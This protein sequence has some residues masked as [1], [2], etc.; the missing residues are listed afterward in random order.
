MSAPYN[1]WTV[2]R[3]PVLGWTATLPA[4][5]PVH[6][7]IAR[8]LRL[9]ERWGVYLLDELPGSGYRRA[10]HGPLGAF[11]DARPGGVVDQQVERLHPY[12]RL[13]VADVDGAVVEQDV[14][15]LGAV[16]ER[17]GSQA[18]IRHH[19]PLILDADLLDEQPVLSVRAHSDV[20]LPWCHADVSDRGGGVHGDDLV[21]NRALAERH[22][23]RLS[24]FLAELARHT[25]AAGGHW[26]LEPDDTLRSLQFELHDEGV[27]LDVAAPPALI[28]P[29]AWPGDGPD[30][31]HTALR[32]ALELARDHP[33]GSPDGIGLRVGIPPDGH[34]LGRA[35]RDE[36]LRALRAPARPELRLRADELAGVVGVD[37][38]TT[39]GRFRFGV[40]EL[41]G[42]PG[43]GPE[44]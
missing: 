38:D 23:P 18:P 30:P 1:R 3:E 37:V 12:A 10:A 44:R 14:A 9:G 19:P 33:A 35:G 28:H 25:R 7:W 13:A 4:H 34:P 40:G 39:G 17:T 22:A 36:L 16:L 15:D 42:R 5:G 32:R 20:W 21:D 43:G 27:R 31:L 41:L 24:G 29:G 8:A 26:V 6:G 11:L 2:A